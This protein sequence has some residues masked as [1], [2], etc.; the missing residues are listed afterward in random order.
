L[1]FA[2][3]G[4]N[5]QAFDWLEKA[6]DVRD[7]DLAFVLRDPLLVPL[8]DDPRWSV[9]MKKMNLAKEGTS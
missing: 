5:D 9:L 6:Y 7:G 4:E 2:Y 1:V 8:H 3:R